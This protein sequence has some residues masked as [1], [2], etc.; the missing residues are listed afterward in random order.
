MKIEIIVFKGSGKYYTSDVVENEED[1]LMFR[2]EFK[3]FIRSNIPAKISD[4]YI[5]IKDPED[6][7]YDNQSFH[8]ALYKYNEIFGVKGYATD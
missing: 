1:I 3:E 6:V 2:P 8:Y 4:G 7:D 5:V